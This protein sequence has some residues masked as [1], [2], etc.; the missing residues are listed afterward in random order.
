MPS[1]GRKFLSFSISVALLLALSAIGIV[2][3]RAPVTPVRSSW[4]PSNRVSDFSPQ[5]FPHFSVADRRTLAAVE[6]VLQTGSNNGTIETTLWQT[7]P[8][9]LSKGGAPLVDRLLA[10]T[11]PG[12]LRE[13]LLRISEIAW[14]RV[15]PAAAIAWTARLPDAT[16]RRS[17]YERVLSSLARIDPAHAVQVSASRDA[18]G[19]GDGK[20]TASLVD[21]W[22]SV[23]LRG[24]RQ[25]SLNLPPGDRRDGCVAR[26]ATVEARS[27]PADAARFALKRLPPG[28]VLDETI[29]TT[30]Y[31]WAGRDAAAAR[32]W[33][34][35]FPDG[36]L[37]DRALREVNGAALAGN[38][39]LPAEGR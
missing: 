31:Y 14:P 24:A 21:S 5:V 26:I 8:D 13:T 16:D 9:L 34:E 11:P 2:W 3:H 38:T 23:D 25:W 15:D 37:R 17:A 18:S 30:V 39:G 35:G 28:P 36:A 6:A 1:S 19:E 10:Q 27:F 33:V 12:A 29:I 22:A 32:L 4:S 20:L 7:L